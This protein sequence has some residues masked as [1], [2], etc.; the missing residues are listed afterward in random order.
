MTHTLSEIP[1][2]CAFCVTEQVV[3]THDN[4]R[5]SENY[6]FDVSLWLCVCDK[7]MRVASLSFDSEDC[8]FDAVTFIVAP[9]DLHARRTF[10]VSGLDSGYC[11]LYS[12]NDDDNSTA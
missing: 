7:E 12:N 5:L 6:S 4:C 3:N 11:V 9:N 1:F 8:R 2:P 10:L